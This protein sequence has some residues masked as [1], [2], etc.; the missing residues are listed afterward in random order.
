[1]NS[2]FTTFTRTLSVA[3]LVTTLGLPALVTAD[4]DAPYQRNCDTPIIHPKKV[5]DMTPHDTD[6]PAIWINPH[7]AAKSLIVGTDKDRNG[8]LYVFDLKGHMLKDKT[9]ALKRPN[10][11]DI[12]YG[13]MLGGKSVDIA[14][15][16][17]RLT[18]KLRVFS[19]PDMTAIDNG[20]LDMFVGE[21]GEDQRALMGISLYKRPSDGAIFAIVGRKNGPSG[22]YLWQYLLHDDGNGQLSAT[23]VRRFG[24]FSGLNEI[25]AIAV[26]DALGYIYYSD[27]GVGVRKYYADPSQGNKELALFATKGF[28]GDHEGISIYTQSNGQGYIL[29]SDQQAN[30]FHIFP[31]QGTTDDPHH[32]PLLKVVELATCESDGSEAT[33]T[34]LGKDYPNGMFVAMSDNCT[35]Q[36]YK[37]E[38]IAGDDL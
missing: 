24:T 1:M 8:G 11:V 27:E 9:V 37:W 18:S 21:Q 19:L 20:G 4:D 26:D 13:L 2:V 3:L 5:T 15:A 17:E 16:T 38:Q 36:I 30:E 29:V 12:E 22:S 34:P 35:F 7:D 31:R 32:H 14:V 23:L 6:D 10:N 25:E 33:S 28:A